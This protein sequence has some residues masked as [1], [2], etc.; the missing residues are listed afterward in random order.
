MGDYY[1]LD[2]NHVPTPASMEEWAQWFNHPNRQVGDDEGFGI[3]VSTIF[4]GL[5]RSF[6]NAPPTV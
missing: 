3:R 4:L 5:D 6:G 1:I 2:D